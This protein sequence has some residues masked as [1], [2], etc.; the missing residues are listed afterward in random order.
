LF[1]HRGSRLSISG[2]NLA[3]LNEGKNNFSSY[4]GSLAI[5][6]SFS[7]RSRVVF[8]TRVGGGLN[9]GT[10]PFYQA[11]VLGGKTEL[12]GYRK[13]RFYGD[14]RFYANFE[15]RIRLMNFRSYLFPASFGI[16]GF[17]DV[18]RIWYKN[19]LGIDPSAADETSDRWHKGWGGGIWFTPFN[20]TVLSAEIGHSKEGT[21]GYLR[22]GFLF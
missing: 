9:I 6:H 13:T 10:Y 4:D 20:M 14:S 11:Q 18:G 7:Q 5:F 19:D 22:L 16:V 3:Q 15:V 12:R 21:Q 2:R 8:A 1:T 17:H